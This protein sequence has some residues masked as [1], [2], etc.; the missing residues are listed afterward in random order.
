LQGLD[1]VVDAAGGQVGGGVRAGAD[2]EREGEKEGESRESESKVARESE[3]A[4]AK[5]W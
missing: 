4:R 5:A 2:G 1:G 3:R